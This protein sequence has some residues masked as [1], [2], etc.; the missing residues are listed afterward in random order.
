MENATEQKLLENSQRAPY[1]P[2][3]LVE[4]GN[5]ADHTQRIMSA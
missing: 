5:A 1:Q 4:Y 3:Q 2:P